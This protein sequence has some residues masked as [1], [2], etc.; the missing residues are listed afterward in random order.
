M[1]CARDYRSALRAQHPCESSCGQL[2]IVLGSCCHHRV[3]AYGVVWADRSTCRCKHW[4]MH[5]IWHR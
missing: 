3:D 5:R 1:C 4:F 2:H